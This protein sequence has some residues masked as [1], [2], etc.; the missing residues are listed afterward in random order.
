MP[1]SPSYLML[2]LYLSFSLRPLWSLTGCSL[3][4]CRLSC[5]FVCAFCAHHSCT[6]DY[7]YCN[8]SA[9]CS[10]PPPRLNC[11]MVRTLLFGDVLGTWKFTQHAFAECVNE[12]LHWSGSLNLT[13]KGGYSLAKN[14]EQM[15]KGRN[16]CGIFKEQS[17][18]QFGLVKDDY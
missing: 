9:P 6:V 8:D 5:S 1:I 12:W 15:C 13:L 10:F 4:T 17:R 11:L 16:A 3:P 7:L 14:S 2:T 18:H